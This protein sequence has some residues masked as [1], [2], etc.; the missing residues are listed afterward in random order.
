M[1]EKDISKERLAADAG[2]SVPTVY[3]WLKHPERITFENGNS[4]A[5][6]L[7]VDLWEI[8]FLH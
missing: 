8:V 3:R 7:G 6:T 4:I 5:K 1:S 2:V